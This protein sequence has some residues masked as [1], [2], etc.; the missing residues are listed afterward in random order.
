M[1]YM[2]M[3]TCTNAKNSIFNEWCEKIEMRNEPK[4]L[5]LTQSIALFLTI[6]AQHLNNLQADALN[7]VQ[8]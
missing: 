7:T 4:F 2:Y 5:K 8:Q 3:Y 1:I 6:P